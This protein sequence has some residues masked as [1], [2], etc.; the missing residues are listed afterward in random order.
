MGAI[1]SPVKL[2]LSVITTLISA[3]SQG[4]IFSHFLFVRLSLS[5]SLSIWEL[6]LKF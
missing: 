4:I 2:L 6:I 3:N 5:L 1:Q